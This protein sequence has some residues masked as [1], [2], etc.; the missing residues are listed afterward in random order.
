MVVLPVPG[1]PSTRNRAPPSGQDVVEARNRGRSL[2]VVSGLCKSLLP[3]RCDRACNAQGVRNDASEGRFFR[4]GE[5]QRENGWR[6]RAELG[7]SPC[8][9]RTGGGC[10][11]LQDQHELGLAAQATKTLNP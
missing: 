2:A 7:R 5:G 10:A 3:R 4:N 11:R 1:L 8:M 6:W 9:G